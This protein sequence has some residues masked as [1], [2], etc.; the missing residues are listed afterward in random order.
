MTMT[1][2]GTGLHWQNTLPVNQ[3]YTDT[4][5]KFPPWLHATICM[6]W[7]AL[8]S[9]FSMVWPKDVDNRRTNY[10]SLMT[11]RFQAWSISLLDLAIVWGVWICSRALKLDEG[12]RARLALFI[13]TN[14]GQYFLDYINFHYSGITIGILL[15][16]MG[17]M[18]M[19]K[20][21]KSG[22]SFC[23]GD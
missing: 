5:T 4:S 7:M 2:T 13:I 19:G 15:A 12:S 6:G 10:N 20:C 3:W 22:G 9:V 23:S 14:A 16:S 8:K 1:F 21:F 11:L 17:Y 18:L